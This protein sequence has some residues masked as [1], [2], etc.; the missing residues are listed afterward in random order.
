MRC[1]PPECRV[2]R[3][4]LI[5]G[6]AAG[7][8][9]GAPPRASAAIDGFVIIGKDDWLFPVFDDLRRLDVAR[10]RSVTQLIIESVAILK[11]GGIETV[12]SVTP[13]KSRIYRDYLPGDYQFAPEVEKRYSMA[14]DL[15]TK[16]GILAPDLSTVLLNLRKSQPD[17]ALFFKADT[18]WTGAGA[19]PAA[20]ELATQ[21]KAKMRL[22][23]S[24]RP[25]TVLGPVTTLRQAGNDL[26]EQLPDALAAKYKPQSYTVH[27]PVAAGGLL[28][29]DA[30]D[31]LLVG[32]SFMQ[33]KYNF[34]SML[35]NQIGRPVSLVWKVH[36]ASPY[37]TLLGALSGKP[38]PKL[39]VWDFQETD[40]VAGPDESNI[41]G[42]NA[43]AGD[44][45]LAELRKT[46]GA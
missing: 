25:G 15:F 8:V 35:S 23:P 31:T 22:S 27:Q 10:L 19:E 38:K 14:L 30:A 21:I 43:M 20:I 34:A 46:V 4:M 3:R 39:L 37:R 32:N 18:H 12:L 17:V 29:D 11:R 42:P 5:A 28:G 44:A 40:M 13:A 45:F 7:A 33:P 16:Q 41:W 24:A 6:A 2:T 9:V 1:Q 26:S 36:Q